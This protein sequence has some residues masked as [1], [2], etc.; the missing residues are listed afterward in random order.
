MI[1]AY[2]PNFLQGRK[3]TT[4]HTNAFYV[5]YQIKQLWQNT[6]QC[7]KIFCFHEKILVSGQYTSKQ[8]YLQ[9][10]PTGTVPCLTV[11]LTALD[12]LQILE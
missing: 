5:L 3:K 6:T 4:V 12:I 8:I 9:C 1:P 7:S 10:P 2:K 11:F